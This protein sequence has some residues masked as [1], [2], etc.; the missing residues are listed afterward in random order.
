MKLILKTDSPE[1]KANEHTIKL[2]LMDALGEFQS[3]RGPTSEAYVNRRYPDDSVY[4]G[5]ARKR[6]IEQVEH[7]K[8][9][10]ELLHEAELTIEWE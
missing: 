9:L 10:A 8:R 4:K 6:K 2:I 1:V 7:R 3:N 5:D